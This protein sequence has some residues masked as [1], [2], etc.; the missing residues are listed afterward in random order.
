LTKKQRFGQIICNE[1]SSWGRLSTAGDSRELSKSQLIQI[2]LFV[3]LF[4]LKTQKLFVLL[5]Y[6]RVHIYNA[7]DLGNWDCAQ[8]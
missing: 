6:L 5:N 3:E 2:S 4:Q 1:I 7:T 8:A